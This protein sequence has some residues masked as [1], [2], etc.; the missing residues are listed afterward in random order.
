MGKNSVPCC[1]QLCML[2]L[3]GQLLQQQLYMPLA[4][5]FSYLHTLPVRT[6]LSGIVT[7]SRALLSYPLAC[8]SFL[9]TFCC[10]LTHLFGSV[11]SAEPAKYHTGRVW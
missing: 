1:D 4:A 10:L 9:P 2:L 11:Y 3:P 6:L 8:L 5:D 7:S